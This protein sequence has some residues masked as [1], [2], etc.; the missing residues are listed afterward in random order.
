MD[1]MEIFII[2]F[3]VYAICT[4][5]FPFLWLFF[6]L[7]LSTATPAEVPRTAYNF[8]QHPNNKNILQI[9]LSNI[10]GVGKKQVKSVKCAISLTTVKYDFENVWRI[11]FDGKPLNNYIIKS[12]QQALNFIINTIAIHRS[13]LQY[14]KFKHCSQDIINYCKT[15]YYNIEIINNTPSPRKI[16]NIHNECTNQIDSMSK[17]NLVLHTDYL[18]NPYCM[19]TTK[20]SWAVYLVTR[21]HIHLI[22]PLPDYTT[23]YIKVGSGFEISYKPNSF[24]SCYIKNPFWFQTLNRFNCNVEAHFTIMSRKCAENFTWFSN[25]A[26]KI[27][28][29]YRGGVLNENRLF[30]HEL[31]YN[32]EFTFF[33]Q[34]GNNDIYY[35]KNSLSIWRENIYF[36]SINDNSIILYS[37]DIRL[38]VNAPQTGITKFGE[39]VKIIDTYDILKMWGTTYMPPFENYKYIPTIINKDHLFILNELKFIHDQF[40]YN[41]ISKILPPSYNQA[42]ST[43]YPNCFNN[44]AIGLCNFPQISSFIP[45]LFTDLS[46]QEKNTNFYNGIYPLTKFLKLALRSNHENLHTFN[47]SVV[48]PR[49]HTLM[50]YIYNDHITNQFIIDIIQLV[51]KFVQI[52]VLILDRTNT[53]LGTALLATNRFKRITNN[54]Y[55]TNG[56]KSRN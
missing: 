55:I 38:N 18:C 28:A 36:T 44:F 11:D 7:F 40:G 39:I 5:L 42:P 23:L 9:N 29:K 34:D 17:N 20:I 3:C 16:V 56:F 4:A 37:K 43:R 47:G 45:I 2:V 33:G 12:N 54:R 48:F 8:I 14:I 52:K 51:L 6:N 31:D 10:R 1:I 41:L 50:L 25:S 53:Q 30:Q 26:Y 13:T 24:K 32:G 46:C 27:M 15:N 21:T 19:L 49:L 22:A 35:E